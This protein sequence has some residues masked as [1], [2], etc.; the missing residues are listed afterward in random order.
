MAFVESAFQKSW[1][2]M[3]QLATFCQVL[4][5]I[6]HTLCV[7]NLFPIMQDAV[8]LSSKLHHKYN[9]GVLS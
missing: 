5:I 8:F 7:L 1:E 6:N 3:F 9:S 4:A 2:S